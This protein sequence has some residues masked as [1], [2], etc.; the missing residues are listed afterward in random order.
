MKRPPHNKMTTDKDLTGKTFNRLTVLQLSH[1]GNG[2]EKYWKCSCSCGNTKII[3]GHALRSGHTKSCGCL[4]KEIAAIRY[5]KKGAEHPNWKGGRSIDLLGYVLINSSKTTDRGNAIRTPEHRL[6]MEKHIG[7]PLTRDETIHHKNGNRQDNRIENLELWSG[8]HSNGQRVSDLLIEAKQIL[9]KYRPE[10]L[11]P[12]V[13]EEMMKL[14]EAKSPSVIH[15]QTASVNNNQPT[16]PPPQAFQSGT[17]QPPAVPLSLSAQ[18][19]LCQ[20]PTSPP[21]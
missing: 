4:Q 1:Y 8:R 10:L 12:K 13:R 2:Y 18:A 15:P 7:R 11:T 20:T 9:L 6:V 21:P 14:N 16:T 17:T 19:S 3:A 5:R